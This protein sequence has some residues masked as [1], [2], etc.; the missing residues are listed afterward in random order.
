[1]KAKL[2]QFKQDQHIDLLA[3]VYTKT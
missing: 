1:M 3:Y 2:A